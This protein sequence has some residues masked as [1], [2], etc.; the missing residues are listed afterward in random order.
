MAFPQVDTPSAGK[1]TAA[2]FKPVPAGCGQQRWPERRVNWP[3]TIPTD[4]GDLHPAEACT[5]VGIDPDPYEGTHVIRGLL[6][7]I[8]ITA[9]LAAV[10][11]VL[12]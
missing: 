3:D 12:A 4:Y 10:V 5:E 11:A 9:L 6:S 2:D 7:A 8:G 1:L